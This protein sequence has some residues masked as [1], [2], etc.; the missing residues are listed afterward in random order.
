MRNNMQYHSRTDNETAADTEEDEV[1]KTQVKQAMLALQEL[2]EALI[3]LKKTELENLAL[4]E[5]LFDA[6]LEAQKIKHWGA[7]KRQKQ[8]IGRL[9]RDVDAEPIQAYLNTVR[10]LSQEHNAWLH[11]L[12]RLRDALL[13]EDQALQTLVSEYPHID[14]Q[15][16]RTLIRN[17]R[18]EKAAARPPKYFRALF[19]TLKTL[20]PEPASLENRNQDDTEGDND[21]FS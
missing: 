21:S 1:S 2:G 3:A 19:Q 18:K 7:L 9:M 16:L 4:P 11:R 8:Y 17:A 15:T 20:I 12:E 6:V 10:G 5:K 14:I 13:L